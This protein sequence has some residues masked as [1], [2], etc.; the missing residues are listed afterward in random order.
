MVAS[1]VE[2]PIVFSCKG[3]R[4]IGVLH[5]PN[6]PQKT[7][8]VVVTGAPQY[9]IG[10]HRQYVLLARYLAE[11]GFPVLRFDYRGMGDSEGEFIGFEGIDDDIHAAIDCI[12]EKVSGL[13]RTVL[14]GLCDGASAAAI[15]A[16]QDARIAGL[17]LIN[18]WVRTL[19]TV[20][21]A[22]IKHYYRSQLASREF[23]HRLLHREVRLSESLKSLWHNLQAASATSSARK[24]DNNLPVRV[25]N[26][27]R[28]YRGDI[29]LILSSADLTAQEFDN[30]VLGSSAMGAWQD[31]PRVSVRRLD[32]ANHTYSRRPWRE[33][34]HRWTES[35][36]RDLP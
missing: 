1:G 35:W 2:E 18:P 5:R 27:L 12:F 10:S 34:V 16:C 24:P 26:G 36:L 23:W 7:G 28:N 9:R 30:T 15:Y 14:W 19:A 8:V 3:D 29:L 20:A 13:Q 11:A 33:Q 22:R 25:A 21:Q 31:N 17:V 6:H 4:L 32:H